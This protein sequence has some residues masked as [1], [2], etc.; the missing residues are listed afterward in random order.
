MEPP[1]PGIHH[2][3]LS[4]DVLTGCNI[5]VIASAMTKKPGFLCQIKK[6]PAQLKT[7]R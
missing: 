1:A 7:A 3:D 6:L 5:P 2:P 4:G